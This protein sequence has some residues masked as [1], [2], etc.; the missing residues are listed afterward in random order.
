MQKSSEFATY[1]SESLQ[2]PQAMKEANVNVPKPVG[3]PQTLPSNPLEKV[4]IL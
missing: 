3:V 4:K 2:A 1:T